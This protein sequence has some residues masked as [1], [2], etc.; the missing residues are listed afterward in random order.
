[1]A[2]ITRLKRMSRSRCFSYYQTSADTRAN[3][4]DY[5]KNQTLVDA[6]NKGTTAMARLLF[7]SL[8]PDTR[9]IIGS[10]QSLEVLLNEALREPTTHLTH[11]NAY[12]TDR[13]DAAPLSPHPGPL[14]TWGFSDALATMG[15]MN[16]T[17]AELQKSSKT[18]GQSDAY[19][20]YQEAHDAYQAGAYH[21]ALDKLDDAMGKSQDASSGYKREWRFYQLKGLL[22]LGSFKNHDESVVDLEKA[23]ACFRLA[24]M[25]AKPKE[26]KDAAIALL[27]A[28]WAA[29]ILASEAPSRYQQS[30]KDVDKAILLDPALDEAIFQKA[31]ILSATGSRKEGLKVLSKLIS[32]EPLYLLK[33]STDGDFFN[34]PCFE[35]YLR[36]QT[37][38]LHKKYQRK[39]HAASKPYFS[40]F[41]QSPEAQSLR[42]STTLDSI[43]VSLKSLGRSST[44]L[45][46]VLR[47]PGH[48]RAIEALPKIVVTQDTLIRFDKQTVQ[49]ISFADRVVDKLAKSENI[50]FRE[51]AAQSAVTSTQLLITLAKDPS[52]IVRSAVLK[53]PHTPREVL[54]QLAQYRDLHSPGNYEILSSIQD[55]KTNERKTALRKSQRPMDLVEDM[56]RDARCDVAQDPETPAR[57]LGK[58]ADDSDR[59]VRSS[60]AENPKTPEK[61]LSNLARD[62]VD[63]VRWNVAQNPKTPPAVLSE[64]ANDRDP[65]IRCEVAKHSAL[66]PGLLAE[67]VNDEDVR[68]RTGIAQNPNTPADVLTQLAKNSELEVRQKVAKNV[69]TPPTVLAQLA[70]DQ[71]RDVR[72]GIAGNPFTTGVSIERLVRDANW[73]VQS[74][75]LLHPH[76]PAQ[77]LLNA[78]NGIWPESRPLK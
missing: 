32:R 33:A 58:L 53:N 3:Y 50:I 46:D 49:K 64:L 13:F 6:L 59:F 37:Q 78:L 18:T 51:F 19:Q 24:A 72:I 63:E 35:S 71:E 48:V 42:G 10:K 23:L 21:N 29:Y 62:P 14:F 30:L 11:G 43:R 70:K 15:G 76:C 36:L 34:D 45:A 61:A 56:H 74:R 39:L 12:Q 25:F 31:K 66:P 55:A 47:L 27:S 2:S 69:Q 57:I 1:M 38:K 73:I 20:H 65:D 60:V 54:H 22:H 9:D 7:K 28:S 40:L 44:D 68:V 75:A 41:R 4:L 8:G 67:F 77:T 17:L 52:A 16:S 5:L 26:P